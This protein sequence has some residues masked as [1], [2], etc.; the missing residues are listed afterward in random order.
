MSASDSFLDM[1]RELLAPLGHIAIKRMFSGA[2]I[3]CDGL[4]F[5]LVEDDVLYLKAGAKTQSRFEAE[6][7][8]PFTYEG[9]TRPVS[10][11]YW[12]VPER[13]YDEPGEMLEWAREAIS[14]ARAVQSKKATPPTNKSRAVKTTTRKA[15]SSSSSK[16]GGK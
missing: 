9:K 12:R 11:S 3:Y 8:G 16:P 13:L 15:K 10:M 6:G 2:S 14:V 5:A 4:I 1:L 7:L